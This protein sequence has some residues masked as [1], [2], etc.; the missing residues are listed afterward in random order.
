MATQRDSSK[1]DWTSRDTVEDINSGSWQ[2]MADALELMAK[3]H[4]DLIRSKDYWK[5]EAKAGWNRQKKNNRKIAALRGHIN[6]MKKL[7]AKQEA[8]TP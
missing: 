5:A 8:L 2:R 6:R 4:S 1:K 3:N 7:Q